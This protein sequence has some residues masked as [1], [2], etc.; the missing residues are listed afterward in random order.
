[1]SYGLAEYA[2]GL[3]GGPRV[4][5]PSEDTH[6]RLAIEVAFTTGALDP[7]AWV[8]VT[9]D[10][11]YWESMRGRGRELE[12]FQPGRATIVF[13]NRSRQYD[14]AYDAGPWFGNLKPMRRLRIRETFSGVTYPVFD[15]FVD[16]W[17]LDYP[18]SGKD[19]V[20]TVIATDGF[21][22]HART[23]LGRSVYT[24][25]VQEDGPVL[26]WRL[27]E[28]QTV[29]DETLTA[30]DSG[31]ATA[32]NG[33]FVG[34]PKLGAE[35]LIVH[36]PGT[37]MQT[38]DSVINPGTPN[39][40]VERGG[41]GTIFDNDPWTIELWC[42]PEVEAADATGDY[43]VAARVGAGMGTGM[44]L[45][46]DNTGG[47]RFGFAIVNSVSTT[48]DVVSATGLPPWQRYHVVVTHGT[49]RVLRMYVNGTKTTGDTTTGTLSNHNELLVAHND[50]IVDPGER[51]WRGT[52]AEVAIYTTALTDDQVAAHYAAGSAPWQNDL[53]GARAGRVLDE[54]EWPADLRE[55]DTGDVTLQSAELGTSALEHLQKVAETEF[56]LL[57]MSR[58]GDVRLV[59]RDAVF[60]RTPD[61]V[62][63]GDDTGEVGYRAITFDDGDTVIRNRATISRLNGV[64]RT[65]EDTASVEEFGRFDYTLDGLLHTSDAYSADYAEFIVDEY[66][67]PRRRVTSL[68]V[69]PPIVGDEDVVVPA[70]LGRELGEAITVRSRPLGGG[71]PFEQ[72]CVIEGIRHRGT[73]TA[74]DGT[75]DS[76]ET[77]FALSPEYSGSF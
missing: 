19:A 40:G 74:G 14:A 41:F 38:S 54:A 56:G 36:D 53:P 69:G 24:S 34:F 67:D 12:R 30:L 52:M 71:D 48:F 50:D 23:D 33:T 76:I 37:G 26:W 27:D 17:V 7:P 46:Y 51:N 65:D 15:G 2:G 32:D 20:A 10:V 62:V 39:Q 11:R 60:A 8:D 57:F 6:P 22:I 5:A 25:V 18:N 64:A 29:A 13:A 1:M 70:Q 45:A 9:G 75:A 47:G 21:K 63:F 77:T 59:A 68:V 31:G 3:Y 73:P 58:T 55:I 61:P 16:R 49:D 44:V 4:E 66:K 43:L 28:N 42:R 72:V 35:G